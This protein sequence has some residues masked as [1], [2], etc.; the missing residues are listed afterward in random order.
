MTRSTTTPEAVLSAVTSL[1][2]TVR[3]RAAEVE[4]ARRLPADL[5]AELRDAGA[6]GILRPPSHGGAGADLVAAGRVFETLARADASV[7][8]TV[9][10]GAGTWCDLVEL[11]RSDFDAVLS[12]PDSIGAGAFSPSGSLTKVAG[13]YRVEG[14]WGFVSGCEHADWLYANGIEGVVDGVPQMRMAV[15]TPD[16]VT[17]EDT[18][19]VSGL[20]GT[21]SHHIRVDGVV[22]PASRTMVPMAGNPC[23]DTPIVRIP[24]PSVFSTFIAALAVGVARGALDDVVDLAA[25]KV[26]LLDHAPLATNARF[27]YSLAV[28]DTDVRAARA[29][30]DETAGWMWAT[31]IAGDELTIDQR[32]AIRAAAAWA[33]TRCASAVDVAYEAGGSSSLYA[34]CALQRRWRDIHALTQHFLVKADTMT[35]AGAILAGQEITVPVF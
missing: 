5:L 14:R 28:A 12:S 2:P 30:L 29:L 26:P 33:T 6:F 8:W 19:N 15:F 13:G 4:A 27:Q 31:A 34:D 17:I 3:A 20:R 32:G 25:G 7:A 9:M 11:S 16:Q 21:G 18:W 23:I 1:T 22:V 35:A 24:P 10:I